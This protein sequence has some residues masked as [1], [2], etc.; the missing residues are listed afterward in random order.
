MQTLTFTKPHILN[1]A[2]VP[3]GVSSDPAYTLSTTPPGRVRGVTSLS[4]TPTASINWPERSFDID[5]ERLPIDSVERKVWVK[6]RLTSARVWQWGQV[7]YELRYGNETE[8]WTAKDL[9]SPDTPV[10]YFRS[11]RSHIVHKN[12]PAQLTIELNIPPAQLKFLL[13]ALI[14]SEVRRLDVLGLGK[15]PTEMVVGAIS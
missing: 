1:G 5:G 9:S 10:A 13:L 3:A 8:E 6:G 11:A 7:E 4:G 2:L 14:Y 12:E 15:R